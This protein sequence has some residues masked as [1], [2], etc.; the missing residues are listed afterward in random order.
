MF[1][2]LTLRERSHSKFLSEILKCLSWQVLSKNVS[3]M[4][5]CLSIFSLMFSS[6][7]LGTWCFCCRCMS[8]RCKPILL[9]VVLYHPPQ[10]WMMLKYL[11]STFFHPNLFSSPSSTSLFIIPHL[12]SSFL[13]YLC[14]CLWL[15]L[16]SMHQLFDPNY[17]TYSPYRCASLL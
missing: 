17:L 15:V 6:I 14:F 10:W 8:N 3:N 16:S 5:L 9:E 13:I 11:S 7:I 12:N 4:F 2:Y 1:S